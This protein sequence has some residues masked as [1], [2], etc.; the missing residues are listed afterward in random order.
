MLIGNK[1]D[2]EEKRCIFHKT[3]TSRDSAILNISNRLPIF[4]HFLNEWWF[5]NVFRNK[6]ISEFLWLNFFFRS[7]FKVCSHYN[8]FI[9]VFRQISTEE[10]KK[11]AVELKAL[12]MET[13]AKNGYNVKEVNNLFL[14]LFDVE[15][16]SIE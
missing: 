15:T 16:E 6:K 10:G 11:K 4:C 9:H 8:C 3:T 7:S 14:I 1:V 12:F 2:L 13:S 5:I